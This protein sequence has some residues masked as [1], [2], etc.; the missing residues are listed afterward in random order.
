MTLSLTLTG[1]D[2]QITEQSPYFVY[3]VYSKISVP[4]F[5]LFLRTLGFLLRTAAAVGAI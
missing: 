4:T 1:I 3:T 5:L 2:A